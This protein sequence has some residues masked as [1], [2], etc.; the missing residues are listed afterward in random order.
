ML[1][2]LYYRTVLAVSCSILYKITLGYMLYIILQCSMFH[3]LY[4]KALLY[5][6]CCI[7]YNDAL[8]IM[9]YI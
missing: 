9:L 6:T 1:N 5:A 2:A 3:A 7:L 4:Y 8:C